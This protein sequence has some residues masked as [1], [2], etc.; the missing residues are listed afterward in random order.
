MKVALEVLFHFRPTHW[1]SLSFRKKRANEY[2]DFDH[3]QF[4][5]RARTKSFEGTE[6]ED[7]KYIS[8]V[9]QSSN[10]NFSPVSDDKVYNFLDV[11][12]F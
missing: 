10:H 7:S 9:P 4:T 5:K 3:M 1:K 8:Y 12:Y 11:L 2:D 6:I